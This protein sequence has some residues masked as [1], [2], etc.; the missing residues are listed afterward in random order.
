MHYEK[1]LWLL[2]ALLWPRQYT[3]ETKAEAPGF[4]AEA[5]KIVPRGTTTLVSSTFAVYKFSM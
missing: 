3:P 1:H 4:E 2:A 5:V